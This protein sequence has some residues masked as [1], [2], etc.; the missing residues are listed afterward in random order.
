MAGRSSSLAKG[1]PSRRAPSHQGRWRGAPLARSR[2]DILYTSCRQSL[3][4][5]TH[6][7]CPSRTIRSSSLEVSSVASLIWHSFEVSPLLPPHHEV[8]GLCAERGQDDR[9]GD[10]EGSSAHRAV[11][12]W[13]PRVWQFFW[14]RQLGPHRPQLRSR[15]TPCALGET[16]AFP[17]PFALE[18]SSALRNGRYGMGSETGP[19]ANER[20]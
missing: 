16:V 13:A 6:L 12:P 1:K 18:R 2:A 7:R 8:G 3:F 9:Y 5:W 14:R 15:S 17:R 11:P 10:N 4:D 19:R 20:I